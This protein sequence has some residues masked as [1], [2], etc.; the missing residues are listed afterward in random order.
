MIIRRTAVHSLRFICLW[1]RRNTLQEEEE[2]V[3]GEVKVVVEE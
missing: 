3:E 1:V 2:E